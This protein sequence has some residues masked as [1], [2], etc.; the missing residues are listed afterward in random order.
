MT[1]S[2]KNKIFIIAVMIFLMACL[3]L[4]FSRGVLVPFLIAAFITYLISPLVAAIQSYGYRR[5]VGVTI[6]AI[7]VITCLAVILMIFVPILISEL[8]KFKI[9]SLDYYKYFSNYLDIIR[10]KVEIYIP[11]IKR[12]DISGI[13]ITKIRDFVFSKAHQI[14]AYLMSIF[15]VFSIIILIPMLVLSMLLGGNKS[16]NAMIALLPASYI[17]TVLSIIYEIDAILGRFIRGWLI[18]ASFVGIMSTI[19]L[20]ILGVNFA[21]IIGLATGI[22]SMI[23]YIGN[24][25]GLILALVVG[26]I[27][28]QTFA[29]AVKIIIAYVIVWFLDNNFI[30]PLA[31]GRNVN[32]GSVMVVFAMLAGGQVF[33]FLGVIFAVPVMAMIKAVLI[34]LIQKYKRSVS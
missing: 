21:L 2:S 16:I 28:F 29:I 6:I 10:D 1:E 25:I 7:I 22:A 9:S 24:F 15:S 4:Y 31:I 17:E 3:F 27:Q 30:Q 12:Y 8:E 34:M 26:V 5:W 32:L 33:G 13:V 18:E 14:P 11:V 20:S 23:P 19:F